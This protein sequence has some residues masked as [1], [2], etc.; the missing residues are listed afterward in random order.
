MPL[1]RSDLDEV[2]R[3]EP[4]KMGLLPLQEE[5]SVLPFLAL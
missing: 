1:G 3:V 2:I 5:T 4:P